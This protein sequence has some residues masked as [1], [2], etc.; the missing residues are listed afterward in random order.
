MRIDSL[1][2]D[3]KFPSADLG[4]SVDGEKIGG[5]GLDGSG[6]EREMVTFTSTF[7]RSCDND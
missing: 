2:E 5:G 3:T 1:H 7:A 4:V 6:R